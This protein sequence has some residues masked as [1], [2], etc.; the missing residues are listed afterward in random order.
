MVPS[1]NSSS[2]DAARSSSGKRADYIDILGRI[3]FSDIRPAVHGISNPRKHAN[4]Y[5]HANR[6]RQN[7]AFAGDFSGKIAGQGK[8][9]LAL[10][11]PRT[12]AL[13]EGQDFGFCGIIIVPYH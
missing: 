7:A 6:I 10:Y 9:C 3:G 13:H 2:L 12:I 5:A 4:Q 8:H 1:R 11:A